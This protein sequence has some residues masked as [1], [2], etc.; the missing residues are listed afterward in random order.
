MRL[1]RCQLADVDIGESEVSDR[2]CK[3]NTERGPNLLFF[4]GQMT[5]FFGIKRSIQLPRVNVL[6]GLTCTVP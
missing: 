5:Q 4:A 6:F 1:F 2:G 3:M